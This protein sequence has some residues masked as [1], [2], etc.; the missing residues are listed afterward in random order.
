MNGLDAVAVVPGWWCGAKTPAKGN[1]CA[2]SQESWISRRTRPGAATPGRRAL[3]PVAAARH[4]PDATVPQGLR[5]R[6]ARRCLARRWNSGTGT[7]R[8]GAARRGGSRDAGRLALGTD[9]GGRDDGEARGRTPD[10]KAA[11]GGRAARSRR[12]VAAGAVSPRADPRLRDCRRRATGD[13]RGL[14]PPRDLP[15]ARTPGRVDPNVSS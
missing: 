8:G 4:R 14:P 3:F 10:G 6:G 2:L 1:P 11:R 5:I 12:P 9:P 7:G 15:T 13:R